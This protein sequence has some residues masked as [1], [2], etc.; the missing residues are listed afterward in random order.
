MRFRI[1]FCGTA[2]QVTHTFEADFATREG[3]KVL[4]VPAGQGGRKMS[5]TQ[6]RALCAL[7]LSQSLTLM[8]GPGH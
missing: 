8:L 2:E 5:W 7:S 6:E 1:H 3:T 4:E